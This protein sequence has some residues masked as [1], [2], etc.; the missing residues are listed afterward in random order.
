M[1]ENILILEW[2][3][4]PEARSSKALEAEIRDLYFKFNEEKLGVYKQGIGLT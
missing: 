4:G 2:R 1:S 3:S